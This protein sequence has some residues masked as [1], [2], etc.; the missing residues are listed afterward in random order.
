MTS[1][2]ALHITVII[3]CFFLWWKWDQQENP[4][5][6]LTIGFLISL[7]AVFV[8]SAFYDDFINLWDERFH[9][10]VA[11][12]L[13]NNLLLPTL[14]DQPVLGTYTLD[15]DKTTVWLHKQPF[16]LWLMSLS[17]QLFGT[18]YWAG[19]L[20]SAG[21]IAWLTY[22]WAYYQRTVIQSKW[23][24]GALLLGLLLNVY[25]HLLIAGRMATD[26]NDAVFFGLVSLSFIYILRYQSEN[27]KH[28]LII[29]SLL[30]GFSILTK[31]LPGLMP[32]GFWITRILFDSDYRNKFKWNHVWI[33][34]TIVIC[35]VVPWQLFAW[36][37]YPEPFALEWD[38]NQR[39]FT[40]AIEGHGG[41]WFF[42]LF[43]AQNLFG[44]GFAILSF[45][46]V[47]K[48]ITRLNYLAIGIVTIEVFFA[49]S[50]T[51]MPSFT[52]IL[53]VP[54]LVLVGTSLEKRNING[55]GIALF[56]FIIA[57]APYRLF[58]KEM[59]SEEKLH[60]RQGMSNNR[61]ILQGL[62]LSKDMVIFN[63]RKRSHIECMFYTD[64]T[65]YPF[66]PSKRDLQK[67]ENAGMTPVLF[68]FPQDSVGM[69]YKNL[70]Q[71][72]LEL[73]F[74]E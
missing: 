61:T 4:T 56:V 23:M 52:L 59:M 26:Q 46:I 7:G 55:I 39:H 27:R 64:A 30:T 67:V 3:I 5:L 22:Q 47:A 72:P 51:K 33:Y 40:E 74:F 32:L 10:L 44:L 6:S 63:A 17:Y 1:L 8:C 37:H 35:M 29:T 53:I 31:W 65:A 19:R 70:K 34:L 50:A 9:S 25:V 60:Y 43:Q 69:Q 58:E 13:R 16:F 15:W 28:L 41:E 66:F 20:P 12:N 71:I 14:Y 42:H 36:K 2:V 38:Y 49:I 18:E 62:N 68:V 11:K 48:G 24:R 45:V 21:L 73:T 57:N 54:L